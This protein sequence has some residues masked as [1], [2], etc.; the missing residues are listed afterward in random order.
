MDIGGWARCVALDT[1]NLDASLILNMQMNH[2]IH[3]GVD[4]TQQ[5]HAISSAS[6]TN[7]ERCVSM[8]HWL[9]IIGT[10]TGG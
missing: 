6:T 8:G 2:G 1:E 9:E 4:A 7:L 3:S 10:H 5:E